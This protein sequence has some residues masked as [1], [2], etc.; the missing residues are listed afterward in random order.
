METG[1][2][3]EAWPLE[4]QESVLFINVINV[5]NTVLIRAVY[6]MFEMIHQY[7]GNIL[8]RANRANHV[9]HQAGPLART[10]MVAPD[11]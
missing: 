10:E 5:S 6:R 8:V 4:S 11:W 2:K 3:F 1:Q 7:I 9:K